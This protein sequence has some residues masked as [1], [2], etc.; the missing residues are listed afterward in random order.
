MAI[1]IRPA[2]WNLFDVPQMCDFIVKLVPAEPTGAAIAPLSTWP[3]TTAAHFAKG[4]GGQTCLLSEFLQPT[5]RVAQTLRA[6]TERVIRWL[7]SRCVDS[8][9]SV[10]AI[11]QPAVQSDGSAVAHYTYSSGEPNSWAYALIS[12]VTLSDAIY[13][14]FVRPNAERMRLARVSTCS[15]SESWQYARQC[16]AS[17]IGWCQ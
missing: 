1:G 15:V 4:D 3:S 7:H 9:G 12:L 8:S 6:R 5:Q 16:D 17:V 10:R 2:A 13:R 14:H 11:L